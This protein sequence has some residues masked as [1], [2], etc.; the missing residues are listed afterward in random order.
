MDTWLFYLIGG[1]T[2]LFS[3]YVRQT[4]MATYAKYRRVPNRSGLTGAEVARAILDTNRLQEIR[5]V[6]VPGK[7]SDHY[8]PRNR[9]IRLSDANARS[10]SVAAM[11][12]SAHEVGHALQD[13]DD[14][15]PL[16]IRSALFPVAQLGARFGIPA[17]VFGYFFGVSWLVAGGMLA[18]LAS[19]VLHFLTL[20]VEFNAS[21][22]AMKQ[23]KQLGLTRGEEEEAA[24]KT[25]RAAAM[26]YVASVA[27]AAGFVVFLGIGGARALLGRPRLPP[28]A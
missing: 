14:Y 3:M 11:A 10:A 25:L 2:F 21:Q 7:L 8:D 19:I 22:R 26:T 4:L 5:V 13:A 9:T 24:R 6:A 23:L 18:Y 12:V 17:A 28:P 20:P 16:E 1:A 27:S 15:G